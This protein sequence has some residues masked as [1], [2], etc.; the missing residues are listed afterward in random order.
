M[1]R[2]LR[3]FGILL[4]GALGACD[5]SGPPSV[6]PALVP[7]ATCDDALSFVRQV[8]LARMNKQIDDQIAAFD[9]GE[10]CYARGG[11]EGDVAGVASPSPP[12]NAPS[13]G[14]TQTTTDD[15]S[16]ATTVSTTNNQVAG[17]DEA[18]FV[19]ND[20]QYIYLAQNGVLRIVDAWPAASAHE[21]SKVPL[22]GD[23]KKLFVVGNRA[24]VYVSVPD[25]RRAPSSTSSVYNGPIYSGGNDCTYGYE[26]NFVGD[27]TS[28]KLEVFDLTDRTQPKKL[29]RR[30][31][32][33]LKLIAARAAS[34]TRPTRSS[35]TTSSSSPSSR[36]PRRKISAATRRA[37]SAR[38]ARARSNRRRWLPRARALGLRRALLRAERA[39]HRK[40][41]LG[42]CVLPFLGDSAGPPNSLTSPSQALHVAAFRSALFDGCVGH[43]GR[44]ARYGERRSAGD[45]EHRVELRARCT[46]PTHRCTSRCLRTRSYGGPWYDGFFLGGAASVVDP[47]VPQS[48]G[49]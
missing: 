48:R 24:L 6:S 2:R 13:A 7:L 18:D 49:T 11:G 20:D 33:R 17:V 26:C 45:G 44:V 8:A 1:L 15:K 32:L 43:D 28:T 21:I 40:Q 3:T 22:D 9:K 16:T 47:Q 12:S 35:P 39:D 31:P 25:P 10:N 38:S 23:P 4:V 46:P 37:A 5:A 27:G 41:E 19:K 30:V 34:A 14:P 42:R 29:R 36:T